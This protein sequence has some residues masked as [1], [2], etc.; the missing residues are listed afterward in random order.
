MNATDY[1]IF[2]GREA[3]LRDHAATSEL[4]Y[5]LVDVRFRLLTFVPTVTAIAVGLVTL[6]KTRVGSASLFGAANSLVV[7]LIGLVATLALVIYEIR[8]SQIHDRAI[9]R[10]MHLEIVLGLRPSYPGGSPRGVFGERGQG[11]NLL[12]L[13][14]V[15]HDRALAM[16]YGVV[17]GAWTALALFGAAEA[18]DLPFT[19]WPNAIWVSAVVAGLVIAGEIGRLGGRGR[20]PKFIYMLD[21]VF[22]EAVSSKLV[23]RDRPGGASAVLAKLAEV[24]RLTKV[25]RNP[26]LLKVADWLKNKA[27]PRRS[28]Q[29]LDDWLERRGSLSIFDL[30]QHLKRDPKLPNE[31]RGKNPLVDLAYAVGVI[32]DRQTVLYWFW[33]GPFVEKRPEIR[34]KRL[35]AQPRKISNFVV[36]LRDGIVGADDV[37][38]VLEEH[39]WPIRAPHGLTTDIEQESAERIKRRYG[40]GVPWAST[41]E[42]NL[43][44]ELLLAARVFDTERACPQHR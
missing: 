33:Y 8:N 40:D 30:A 14:G 7:G 12:G 3:I 34:A 22:R 28:W 27:R 42:V 20:P 24:Q 4:Y 29:R 31:K 26:R 15:K 36:A 17:A 16:I 10:L 37:Y 6:D 32:E 39:A 38:A 11:A 21:S 5:R 43:R 9:H 18:I 13:V 44:I 25:E 19:G 41:K 35:I 2:G 1:H 23:N